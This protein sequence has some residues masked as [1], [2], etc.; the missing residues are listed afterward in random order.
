MLSIAGEV[1][2]LDHPW[3]FQKQSPWVSRNFTISKEDTPAVEDGID[4]IHNAAME[5]DDEMRDTVIYDWYLK[6]SFIDHISDEGF[7]YD[8][9]RHSNFREYGDFAN[10]P[11]KVKYYRKG[12]TFWRDGGLYFPDFFQARLQKSFQPKKNGLDF[13]ID[14]TTDAEQSLTYVLEHNFHFA[15]YERLRLSE[16]PYCG[17][18][19]RKMSYSYLGEEDLDAPYLPGSGVLARPKIHASL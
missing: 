9:F 16:N 5:I 13:S 7:C 11:F 1:A 2:V 12:M 15:D 14:L 6:N 10:Q 18:R 8:N 4:T 3:L 17:S 19:W